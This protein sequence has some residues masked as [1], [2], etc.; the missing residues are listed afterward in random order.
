[1][2]ASTPKTTGDG[3][4]TIA[5]PTPTIN[6][7]RIAVAVEPKTTAR[8]TSP[9]YFSSW[10]RRAG[11]TGT[12]CTRFSTTVRPSRSRKNSAKIMMKK[13]MSVPKTFS[14]TLPPI[15]AALLRMRLQALGH[16][17]LHLLGGDRGVLAHPFHGM[18]DEG[19]AGEPVHEL[20]V[21]EVRRAAE[22]GDDARH[23]AGEHRTQHREGHEHHE[24]R[25]ARDEA[26]GQRSAALKS[27]RQ[28][29]MQRVERERQ[30]D[31]P[32]QDAQERGHDAKAEVTEDDRRDD[33]EATAVEVRMHGA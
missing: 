6:P 7:D 18:P 32:A 33:E 2:V 31:A 8:V 28:P 21:G 25:H 3:S 26:G 22:V 10:L 23:L 12:S 27:A 13:P 19:V 29:L 30:H 1:M 14:A 16:P 4:F 9:R 17:P 24:G 11:S 20:G 5:K 15:E